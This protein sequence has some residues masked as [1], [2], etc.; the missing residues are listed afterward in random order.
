[1]DVDLKNLIMR[2]FGFGDFVFRDPATMNEVARI[3]NLKDLQNNIFTLPKESLLYHISHNNV[4][5]WLG[6]R[7][8]FPIANFLKRITWHSLQ[9]IDAHRQIIFDAIV[10]YRKM[11]N[12]GVVAVFHR[13]RFDQ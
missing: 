1:M 8:L 7:A 4:S 9:D 3:R 2:Y 11:K 5:R 6:S 10:S 12:Q 13:D